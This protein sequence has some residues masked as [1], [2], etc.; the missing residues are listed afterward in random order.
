MFQ[1]HIVPSDLEYVPAVL[2]WPLPRG[3]SG[4]QPSALNNLF[5]AI[6]VVLLP[7]STNINMIKYD[8]YPP[9]TNTSHLK[10]D[11]WNI[12]FFLGFGLF[13]GATC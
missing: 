2:Q 7:L 13:S 12:S 10:M 3:S 11:G 4:P 5:A 6:G 1:K 9:E 8:P